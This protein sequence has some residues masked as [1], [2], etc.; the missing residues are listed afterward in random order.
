MC[1]APDDLDDLELVLEVFLLYPGQTPAEAEGSPSR[2]W[3]WGRE[4][5][6]PPSPPH[7]LAAIVDMRIVA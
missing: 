7:S 5:F 2:R 1:N 4:V 3:R 6:A